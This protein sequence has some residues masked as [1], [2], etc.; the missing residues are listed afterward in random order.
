MRYIWEFFQIFFV[1]QIRRKKSFRSVPS[2]RSDKKICKRYTSDRNES[3]RNSIQKGRFYVL[4]GVF[5]IFW[6]K[7]NVTKR[8]V[9]LRGSFTIH[10]ST[11]VRQTF[12]HRSDT[13]VSGQNTLAGGND[14]VGNLAELILNGWLWVV[15]VGRHDLVLLAGAGNITTFLMNYSCNDEKTGLYL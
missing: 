2:D 15:E 5:Q 3:I 13:L 7:N 10:T 8:S 12:S 14:S 6:Q 1:I 11:D 9:R 4:R